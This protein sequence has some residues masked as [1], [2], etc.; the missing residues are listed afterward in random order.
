[1][2]METLWVFCTAV[3]IVVATP[4][5]DM[6]YITANGISG[7]PKAGIASVLGV[8]TGAYIHVL[9]AAFGLNVILSTSLLAYRAVVLVG[10]LY[11]AYIGISALLSKGGLMQIEAA[12]PRPLFQIWQQGVLVNLTNPKAVLF[13][14][15]FLPQFVNPKI[16]PVIPQFLIL[17][18]I[19]IVTMLILMTPIA[20]Y[21]GRCGDWLRKNPTTSHHLN[22][23]V[24]V[25]FL[26]MAGWIGWSRWN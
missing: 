11:L 21:S 16:G 15:S 4:G 19:I 8:A 2:S 1:M 25:F 12:P 17:G 22:Q 5:A 23:M 24:G 9:L 7:G 20:I 6:L 10:A 18:A 26:G 13:V 3:V 14:L